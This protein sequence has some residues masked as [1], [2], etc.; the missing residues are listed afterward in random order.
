MYKR[1]VKKGVLKSLKDKIFK[2]QSVTGV[3]P[4]VLEVARRKIAEVDE[5]AELD[6]E[7]MLKKVKVLEP[8]V[9][10]ASNSKDS[11]KSTKS[12]KSKKEAF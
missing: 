5:Y 3:S 8:K 1:Q 6:T 9:K 12:K 7:A 10:K 4:S 11:K 2:K